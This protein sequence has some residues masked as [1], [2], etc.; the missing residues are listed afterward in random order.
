MK[1]SVKRF[2]SFAEMTRQDCQV[3]FGG[4]QKACG[5]DDGGTLTI[6]GQTV[7]IGSV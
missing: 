1:P 6:D 4:N 3:D 2:G 5:F 7:G